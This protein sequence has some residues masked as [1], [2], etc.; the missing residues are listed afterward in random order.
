MGELLVPLF[1]LIP[2]FLKI[3]L[4]LINHVPSACT[5]DAIGQPTGLYPL[6]ILP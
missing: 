5:L 4:L 6:E 2:L 3:K 1:P